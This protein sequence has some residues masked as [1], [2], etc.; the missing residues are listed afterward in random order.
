[1]AK[2]TSV[3]LIF[4]GSKDWDKKRKELRKSRKEISELICK[5]ESRCYDTKITVERLPKKNFINCNKTIIKYLTSDGE[6]FR[7]EIICEVRQT[8]SE[9]EFPSASKFI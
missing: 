8:L 3:Q 5:I 4:E 6:V 2:N 1:M 7:E 9:D